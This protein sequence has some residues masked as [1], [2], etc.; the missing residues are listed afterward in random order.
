MLIKQL[1]FALVI[2]RA[3]V[4]PFLL[5]DASDGDVGVYFLIGY[6]AGF[7]SDIFD[8][9][10][11]RRIGVSNAQLRQADSW[12]DVLFYCCIFISAWWVYPEIVR[13]FAWPLSLLALA[14]VLWWLA[15]L[16]KYGKPAAY[17][18]YS[19]KFWGITLFFATVSLFG[20]GYAG[21]P[22]WLMIVAGLVHTVEE[23]A[24][25]LVLPVWR[26]DVLSIF[27]AIRLRRQLMADLHA[28]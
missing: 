24:M 26:H 3:V 23:I 25:T 19:A 14:Q 18:T 7:L 5:W 9:V 2:F 28:D 13:A 21:L 22:M 16:Y 1:P 8:G 10:I 17:H 6:I 11:A 15:N 20:F 27:H 12:A 4:A